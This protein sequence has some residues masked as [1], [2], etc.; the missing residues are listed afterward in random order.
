VGPRGVGKTVLLTEIA[1]RASAEHAWPRLQVEVAPAA[2]FT[3]QLIAGARQVSELLGE[4]RPGERLRP[5]EAIVRAHLACIGGGVHLARTRPE[6][7]HE[8]LMLTGAIGEL[9]TQ[10]LD[11]RT[12]IVLTV[13]ELQ[14]ADRGEV[15]TFGALLQ[16]AA[17]SGWP[18]VVVIAGLPSIRDGNRIPS[19]FERPNGTSSALSS[20]R[21]PST[22]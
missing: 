10:L 1:R 15:M 18:F 9:A 17:G 19:Y 12:G 21:P 5:T 8:S 3:P 4:I 22:P 14:F 2:R 7:R 16:R 6:P 20:T 13:D 11:R